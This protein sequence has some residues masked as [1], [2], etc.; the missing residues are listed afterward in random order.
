MNKAV[1][2]ESNWV[3]PILYESCISLKN[4]AVAA[5][6]A[7][8]NGKHEFLQGTGRRLNTVFSTLQ[9]R[10]PAQQSK[11][12]GAMRIINLML[13]VYFMLSNYRLC[14]P[15]AKILE[16]P[17]YPSL[18]EYPLSHTVT[19]RY[20]M[21]RLHLLDGRYEEAER[22]LQQSFEQMPKAGKKNFQQQKN[23]N[24]QVSYHNKRLVLAY[25]IPAKLMRGKL[26][27]KNL[28][29]KYGLSEYGPLA[30]AVRQGDMRLFRECLV[31]NEWLFRRRGLFILLER[32]KLLVYRTLFRRTLH[33]VRRPGGPAVCPLDALQSALRA[34]HVEM[35][36]EEVECVVANLIAGKLVRGYMATQKD[37]MFVIFSQKE[38]FPIV[39]SVV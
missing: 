18:D 20:Y 37:R 21:G 29:E 12:R 25:L 28:L 16:G 15:L 26:P 10:R 5:D 14:A 6:K 31:R 36:L 33:F 3:L 35:D 34:S 4:C 22:D 1:R 23:N 13:E 8:N 19:Y 2:Q 38:A 24:A 27:Q 7:S 39:S 11:K 30:D 9:D 32:L 17:G